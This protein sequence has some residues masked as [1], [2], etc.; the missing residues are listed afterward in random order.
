MLYYYYIT[1]ELHLS[2]FFGYPND[3]V[4]CTYTYTSN[5]HSKTNNQ[6]DSQ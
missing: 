2:E 6:C 1:V 4:P 5:L 3:F